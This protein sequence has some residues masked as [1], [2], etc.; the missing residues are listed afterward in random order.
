MQIGENMNGDYQKYWFNEDDSFLH[1]FI[2]KGICKM[3][4]PA[5]RRMEVM[6]DDIIQ[7]NAAIKKNAE[8][9]EIKSLELQE[10][11]ARLQ[12]RETDIMQ[13]KNRMDEA[14]FQI[15]RSVEIIQEIEN[16]LNNEKIRIEERINNLDRT[17][18]DEFERFQDRNYRYEEDQANKLGAL[19]RELTWTRWKLI[20]IIENSSADNTDEISCPICGTKENKKGLKRAETDCIFGGGHLVRYVCPTC[21]AIFGP[22]KFSN[23]TPQEHD[24]DYVI[25]YIGYKEANSTEGEMATFK[26]LQPKKDGVYLNYGCGVWAETIENLNQ[27]G[28]KVFGY[29]PYASDIDNPYIISDIEVL[30]KMRFD[31][32]FSHDLLE[33]LASPIQELLFMKTLLKNTSS[34]MAHSTA[35]YMYKYEYT[36][37]HTC[38]FTGDAVSYLCQRTGLKVLDYKD[39]GDKKDFICYVYGIQDRYIDISAFMF[40]K[41]R[42]NG[43]LAVAGEGGVIWGPYFNLEKSIYKISLNIECSEGMTSAEMLVTAERGKRVIMAL[44]VPVGE[45]E[46]DILLDQNEQ[47]V[48]FVF[49]T[50][51]GQ[52]I[53]LKHI[54][55]I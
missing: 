2:K 6:Q 38:F 21:G 20:D 28:Y 23:Q 50:Q 9:L 44:E 25:H 30:K 46:Q 37:F 39:D 7:N 13:L 8:N 49:R 35:C 18:K 54:G 31:G 10:I 5:F 17:R 22:L 41:E 47:D 15:E 43:V 4:S 33:H 19:A 12:L 51:K 24:D 27:Q 42:E 3:I 1:R 36:R 55:F 32:I 52:K 26:M 40:P 11:S 53:V 34:K 16:H 45:S 29:E 14:S 48:E